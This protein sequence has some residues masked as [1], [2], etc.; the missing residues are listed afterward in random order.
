M[1]AEIGVIGLG[2]MGSMAL[3]QLAKEGVSVIGF[4]QFGIGHDRSASGG[5]TRVFR[6]AYKEGSNYIPFLKDAYKLWRELE[7]ETGNDLL[8]LTKGLIIG[9]PELGSIKN[10][11][12][13]IN[14]Y[15]LAH[16][17]LGKEEAEHRFPQHW[18]FPNEQMI[19]DEMAGYLRPQY[20][21]I[22]AVL[23]ARDLGAA[24]YSH[25]CVD[26]LKYEEDGVSIYANGEVFHVGKVI[27]TAGPWAAKFNKEFASSVQ[28]RRLVNSWFLPKDKKQF[29]EQ[30][31]P[32]FTRESD[33]ISYYGFPSVDGCM[34]KIGVFS[35]EKDQI[36][37]PES[38]DR[39]VSIDEVKVFSEFVK[40]YLPDLHCD[41]SRVNAYME[42]YTKDGHPIIGKIPGNDNIIILTG[43]SGHGFKMAPVMGKIGAQLAIKGNTEYPIELFTP[44]RF[45]KTR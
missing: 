40:K 32:V 36:S 37:G 27:I 20:S 13:S 11:M 15:N 10:V 22:S 34:V 23:R 33:G 5:E 43:F 38:L 41:P 2:A 16:E 6:T 31:F 28:V 8:Q 25:T 39:S 1:N 21:I 29:N 18:L 3:W 14:E 12:K 42:I 17:I 7:D 44:S 35:T 30:K 9:D 24:V 45:V 19:V 26:S 4:E